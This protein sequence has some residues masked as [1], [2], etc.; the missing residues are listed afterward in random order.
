MTD[1][2]PVRRYSSID[3][4]NLEAQRL[5]AAGTH[6]P[7]WLVAE[8][9]VA[10]KGR[11]GRIWVSARGNLYSSLL[12]PLQEAPAAAVSQIAF[13]TALAVHDA[14]AGFCGSDA[15]RLKWPN[16]CLLN[17]GKVAGILCETAMAGQVVIGCGINVAHAP[18]GLAYATAHVAGVAPSA[19]VES[20]FAAYAAALQARLSAW[21]EGAG[22]P[23]IMAAWQERAHGLNQSVNVAT[24]GRSLEGTF[25]GLAEDGALRVRR[26]DGSIETVYAGDVTFTAKTS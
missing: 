26:A 22:F 16:D 25:I 12:L 1:L 10:G 7:L 14:V 24:G 17:G 20:V 6:G 19:T 15:V 18:E 9:Q 2:F 11:L 5:A 23:G 4:T 21:R 8:E 3:S 13:V